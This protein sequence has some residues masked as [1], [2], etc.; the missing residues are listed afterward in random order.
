LWA[1]VQDINERK[2]S[3]RFRARTSSRSWWSRT[4]LL[5]VRT[6]E[7][8]VLVGW[9]FEVG[10]DGGYRRWLSRWARFRRVCLDL[11]YPLECR[12]PVAW[13]VPSRRCRS[14][15]RPATATVR[16]RFPSRFVR[17]RRGRRIC[18]FAA[19]L[20]RR[21]AFPWSGTDRKSLLAFPTPRTSPTGRVPLLSV[22]LSEGFV[23][24]K[25]EVGD[26]LAASGIFDLRVSSRPPDQNHFVDAD[27]W[28]MG[29]TP[30]LFWNTEL[31]QAPDATQG[32]GV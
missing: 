23:D 24:G 10:A 12:A 25:R 3:G 7:L 5:Q 16:L 9:C 11:S 1:S 8:E 18:A 17:F 20:L 19:C 22:T 29:F 32:I 28:H 13:L 30:L 14:W 31:C 21:R 2:R 4:V 27:F 15:T 6:R 26:G